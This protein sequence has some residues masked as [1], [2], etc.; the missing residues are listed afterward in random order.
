[1][2]ST[3]AVAA[4]TGTASMLEL[5]ADALPRSGN[6]GE[7]RRVLLM[8]VRLATGLGGIFDKSGSL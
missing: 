7:A 3:A 1:M 6:N 5:L 8:Y 4:T 2:K